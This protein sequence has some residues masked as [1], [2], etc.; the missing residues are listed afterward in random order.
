[1]TN[2]T[3]SNPAGSDLPRPID[4]TSLAAAINPSTSELLLYYQAQNTSI[5]EV[6]LQASVLSGTDLTAN[7]SIVLVMADAQTALAATT[8]KDPA[9]KLARVCHASHRRSSF[10]D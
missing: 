2:G 7:H 3:N 10:Q 1:M 6:S 4:F 8:W 5:V 9:T